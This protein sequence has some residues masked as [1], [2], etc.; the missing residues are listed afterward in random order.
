MHA[1]HRQWL[2]DDVQPGGAGE[3]PLVRLICLDD[4]DPGRQ[5]DVLWSL[6]LGAQVVAP[7]T[8]RLGAPSRLDAP[9]HFGA[10]LHALK[11]SAVSSA[12]ATVF[13]APFRA[14]I[15]LMAHQLTPLMKALELPR[16]NRF[17]A[18]DVGLGKTIEAG[19]VLQ[20]LLLRRGR[21]LEP[22]T[23]RV[24][25]APTPRLPRGVADGTRRPGDARP[26]RRAVRGRARR[27]RAGFDQ[28][29]QVGVSETARRADSRA[30]APVCRITPQAPSTSCCPEA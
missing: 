10:Y 15:K 24:P 13:Q 11:W 8:H 3:S 5:I 26:R 2:V 25:R 29:L 14:G 7:G 17:I 28:S 6:E 23:N 30:D 27:R 22:G 16:A 4:D 9:A 19:L 21:S 20:E 1:R 12:D 18:D